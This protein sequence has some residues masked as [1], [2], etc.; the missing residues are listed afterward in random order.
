MNNQKRAALYARF[1][2]EMQRTESIDAQLRAMH[3][4]CDEHQWT[5]VKEYVDELEMFIENSIIKF[6]D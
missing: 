6:K 2:S 3:E 5:V 4:Y 1:S